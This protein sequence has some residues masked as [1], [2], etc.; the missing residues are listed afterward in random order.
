M[1]VAF[2]TIIHL[3]AFRTLGDWSCL[4]CMSLFFISVLPM[5]IILIANVLREVLCQLYHNASPISRAMISS[6]SSLSKFSLPES[7]S[8]LLSRSPLPRGIG[9]SP[10]PRGNGGSP[11]GTRIGVDS[12]LRSIGIASSPLSVPSAS[13]SR[14]LRMFPISAPKLSTCSRNSSAYFFF[15]GFAVTTLYQVLRL[16]LQGGD[17][18]DV[19]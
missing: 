12:S 11:P 14:S 17:I 6:S 3:S 5:N 4:P 10:L 9:S 2:R 15:S 1:K 8:S 7:N 19:R 13:S 16:H 18:Y